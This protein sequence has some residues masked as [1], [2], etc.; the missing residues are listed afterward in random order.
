MEDGS[1]R[2][3]T[4]EASWESANSSIA[5]VSPVGLVVGQGIGSTEIRATYQSRS[6]AL[7][8]V[9]SAAEALSGPPAALT[10]GTER[11]PVKTL[12][13]SDASRV[14]VSRIEETTIKALNERAAHCAALPSARTYAEEFEVY[15]LVGRVTYVRLEDDRDYHIA[16]TDPADSRYS[17][18]TEVADIACQGAITSPH[19]G[20]LES[21]RNAFLAM[22]GGRMPSTLVG[23][24][25]RVRGVGFYD[26]DHGQRGRAGNCM[27]LHPV[28]AIEQ[29][30]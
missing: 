28:I 12:S 10:C 13:D 24:T 2:S 17:L 8:V 6:G 7:D 22:L 23:A 21:A 16:I 20:V 19:R 5:I 11:W 30:P 18:V 1:S 26:F 27:E 3:V 25:I 14:A 9:V 29:L 4:T 15:E